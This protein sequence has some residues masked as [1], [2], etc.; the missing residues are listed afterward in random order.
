MTSTLSVS[1]VSWKSGSRSSVRGLTLDN[2]PVRPPTCGCWSATTA[3]AIT[4][5]IASANC[6]RSVVSTPHSPEIDAKSTHAVPA[7][8]TVSRRPHPNITLAILIAASVT[9]DMIMMLKKNP[10]YTARN[11]RTS[12]AGFPAYRNS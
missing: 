8:S 6:T 7:M 4:P 9:V 10:R 5:T 11:P 3:A 2:I 12:A 1:E